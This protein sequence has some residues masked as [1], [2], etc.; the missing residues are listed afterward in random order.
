MVSAGW[1]A[2]PLVELPESSFPKLIRIRVVN[3]FCQLPLRD[4]E[5]DGQDTCLELVC[6]WKV[7]VL[8]LSARMEFVILS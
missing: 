1:G 3:V 5:T 6:I 4:V 8:N 2:L 7:S